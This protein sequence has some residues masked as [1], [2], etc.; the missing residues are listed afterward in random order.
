ML[1]PHPTGLKI[2]PAADGVGEGSRLLI[3][4]LE[5][6]VFVFTFFGRHRIPRHGLDFQLYRFPVQRIGLKAVRGDNCHLAR[7][8]ECHRASVFEDGRNIRCHEHLSLPYSNDHPP[9]VSQS[10]GY[11]FVR[12]AGG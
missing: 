11:D 9:G 5:H 1:E 3:N 2:R 8:K 6:E 10:G 7:I 4:F 12:L